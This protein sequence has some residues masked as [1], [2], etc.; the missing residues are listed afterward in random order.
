MISS[1][2]KFVGNFD[3]GLLVD[4]T[5]FEKRYYQTWL[6][7]KND[8]FYV[9]AVGSG[10]IS[11][12]N[13]KVGKVL[14]NSI[15]SEKL[16][17]KWPE[18]GYFNFYGDLCFACRVPDRQWK[19]GITS[20][21]VKLFLVVPKIFGPAVGRED[22]SLS[23][24]YEALSAALAETLSLTIKQGITY[25]NIN[26]NL[27]SIALNRKW[28]LSPS[29]LNKDSR[30]FLYYGFRLVGTVNLEKNK[31][32]ITYEPLRQEVL[33]MIRDRENNEWQV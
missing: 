13:P 26:K 23:N 11:L 27:R 19:R 29:L 8:L 10:G 16:E 28:G 21:N 20:K 15:T 1:E 5:E 31:I 12:E 9:A 24:K 7:Y 6:W 25:L 33:D 17:V 18:T 32:D 14:L 2:N 22:L 30:F 3:E 4:M